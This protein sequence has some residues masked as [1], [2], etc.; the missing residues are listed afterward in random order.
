VTVSTLADAPVARWVSM[1]APARQLAEV[2][3]GTQFVP[4]AMRGDP[5]AI[6]AAILYGDEL[7]IDPMQSL[8]SI[9]VVEGRPQ[10]SS[11]LTRALILRAGHNLAVHEMTGT[12]VRVSG[13]RHGR[14]ESERVVVEWTLDMARAAGLAGRQNWRNY[15]RAMLLAR[16]FSDLARV[17]FPDVIKGL[18]YVVENEDTASDLEAWGAGA[19]GPA[20]EAPQAPRKAL[21]RARRPKMASA[22]EPAPEPAP[23]P[24]PVPE[25]PVAPPTESGRSDRP[26]SVADHSSGDVYTTE[27]PPSAPPPPPP[28]T[29]VAAPEGDAPPFVDLMEPVRHADEIPVA[30]GGETPQHLPPEP[31]MPGHVPR[32]S[33]GPLK[34][35]HTALTKELGTAATDQERHKMLAAVTGRPI[36]SSK[37]LTRAEGYDVLSFLARVGSGQASYEMD[38]ESGVFT[39]HDDKLE[40]PEES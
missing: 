3:A 9:H 39:V 1:L 25:P 29:G 18:G 17:L 10:P 21:Q 26:L 5:D 19:P 7:G 35:V 4:T 28:P 23:K 22:A 14:P 11:E 33:A 24:E 2:L 27:G 12:R 38:P 16:A 13:L 20:V 36:E 40:P 31:P 30:D 32:I 8:A 37:D 6:A 34:A 15:P